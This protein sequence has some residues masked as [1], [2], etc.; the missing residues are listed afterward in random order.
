M[1]FEAQFDLQFDLTQAQS[2]HVFAWLQPAASSS[3][4]ST[5]CY[6]AGHSKR[7]GA[8]HNR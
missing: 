4:A 2:S 3:S 7:Q 6:R 5:D 8:A 1:S